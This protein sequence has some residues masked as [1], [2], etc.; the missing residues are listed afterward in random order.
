MST[1]TIFAQASGRGSAGVAVLR[2]SGPT[3]GLALELLTGQPVPEPRRAVVRTLWTPEEPRALLDQSLVLWFPGPASFTG[4]DVVELHV[5]GG[6]AVIGAVSEAVLR[7][8]AVRLAEPG[9]FSRRAFAHGRLD[10][11]A[12]EAQADLVAAETE[13]QR[14]QALRQL[15]GELA[16][17]YEGWRRALVEAVALLEA[18]IDFSDQDLPEGIVGGLEEVLGTLES[19]IARH[20]ADGHRGEKV[21]EGVH[22]A[23]V[24]EPNAGK[25]SL[26][27]LLARREV[28]IVSE[29]P[30]TTRDVLEVVLD[31]E[32]YPVVLAD[33]AGLRSGG[34]VVEREGMRRARKRAE[35][36]DLR[37]LV[38]DGAT[39]PAVG[40]EAAEY[41]GADTL[42]VVSKGDLLAGPVDHG[43]LVVSTR[44]GYNVG[45]LVDVLAEEVRRRFCPGEAPVLTRKRHRV[46]LE[47]ALEAV[48]RARGVVAQPELCAE[49][50]RGASVAIGR[51]TGRVDVE[52]VLDAIFREF[53]I[54]K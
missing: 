54:G 4:E 1:E 2:L 42:V 18:S 31:L 39:W 26:F 13:V 5:H 29:L 12:A 44:T 46:E 27:N 33:T 32:G 11:T 51:I 48:M 25:S 41:F 15:H 49:D 28:A 21:R 52:E 10:L 34:D 14:S 35:T 47:E 8:P 40:P 9:E 30:G 19:A 22:I 50:L 3:A 38:L 7:C 36:A 20:L 43:M 45:Q 17:L 37:L 16:S 24:G 23:I 6:P 53:C